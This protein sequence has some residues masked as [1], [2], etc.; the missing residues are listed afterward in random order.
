MIRA[1]HKRLEIFLNS[2]AYLNDCAIVVRWW[3]IYVCCYS[4]LA[5]T[6]LLTVESR[7]INEV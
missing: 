6:V 4:R 5:A 7:V 1:I 2:G 3:D